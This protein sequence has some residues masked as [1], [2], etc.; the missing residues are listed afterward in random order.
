MR[1]QF[2]A[3]FLGEREKKLRGYGIVKGENQPQDDTPTRV[4]EGSMGI[5]R[6]WENL[7]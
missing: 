3:C 6:W 7:W 5:G 4:R 1:W 2:R